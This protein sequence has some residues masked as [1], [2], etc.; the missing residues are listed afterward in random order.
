MEKKMENDFKVIQVRVSEGVYSQMER[1]KGKRGA[2][3]MS[4][5]IRD[6]LKAL[7]TLE[8][9]KQKDGS[10]VCEHNGDRVKIII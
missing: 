3:S 9:L 8:E 7:N 2:T 6:G 1:L 5:V 4:Q 10:V